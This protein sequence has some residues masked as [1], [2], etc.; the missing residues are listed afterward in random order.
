M[1]IKVIT[2]VLIIIVV[3]NDHTHQ[4]RNITHIGNLRYLQIL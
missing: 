3:K 4:I 1:Q 2:D